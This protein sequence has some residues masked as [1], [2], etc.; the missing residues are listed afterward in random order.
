MSKEKS[1]G[2]LSSVE[3]IIILVFFIAFLTWV[4]PKC[5]GD[6]D[7]LPQPQTSADSLAALQHVLDS[8]QAAT[9]PA[10]EVQQPQTP[11]VRTEVVSRLYVTIDGLKVRKEPNLKSDMVVQLPLFEEVYFMDEVT[12]FTEEI[13]LGYEVA[14]EPWVKIRTKKGHEGWVYG[15]GINYYKQKRKGVLE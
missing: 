12:D 6:Q 14:N 8:I 15:A 3:F 13:S 5:Q 4:F 7:P 1:K 10:T 11:E 9:A 2:I